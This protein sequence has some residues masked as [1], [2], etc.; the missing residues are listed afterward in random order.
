MEPSGEAP[1]SAKSFK[2]LSTGGQRRALGKM[3][4]AGALGAI[5][6]ACGLAPREPN[7][8]T[9]FVGDEDVRRHEE[10]V[11][12]AATQ[13]EKDRIQAGVDEHK[14]NQEATQGKPYYDTELNP[15]E[16][17]EE[18]VKR[19]YDASLVFTQ[20]PQES[21]QNLV[22][23]WQSSIPELD[24]VIDIPGKELVVMTSAVAAQNSGWL[25]QMDLGEGTMI[26]V[27]GDPQKGL[28]EYVRTHRQPEGT[29]TPRI[30]KIYTWSSEAGKVVNS[31]EHPGDG[32]ITTAKEMYL[33]E[34][35]L[36]P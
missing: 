24:V 10:E 31:D 34:V 6:A 32:A 17:V 29:P 26:L 30:V 36:T 13:V 11:A 9:T 18:A 21:R 28:C 4:L 19:A 23:T 8:P 33:G 5:A 1:P 27:S 22:Q 20:Y 15:G 12:A 14:A 3:T 16:R 2:Q 7:P 25:D 35:H